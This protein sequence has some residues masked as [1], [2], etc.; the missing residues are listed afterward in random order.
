MYTLT[1]NNFLLTMCICAGLNKE[2]SAQKSK[3]LSRKKRQ[4]RR[5]AKWGKR[6]E[7]HGEKEDKVRHYIMHKDT[8]LP[9]YVF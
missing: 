7:E 6:G 4:R 1:G 9:V 3:R 8:V 5:K 2:V